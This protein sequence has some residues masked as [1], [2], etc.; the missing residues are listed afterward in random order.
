VHI[1]WKRDRSL[2]CVG[3]AIDK[4]Y[5][6]HAHGHQPLLLL[7]LLLVML[8]RLGLFPR[9]SRFHNTACASGGAGRN[10]A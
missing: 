6:S 4:W 2:R 7:L 8:R 1:F 10:R 3:N 9:R 5:F